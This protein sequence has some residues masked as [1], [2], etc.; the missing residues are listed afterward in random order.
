MEEK[1]RPRG[2]DFMQN[3]LGAW[4]FL[5]L[6]AAAE[7]DGKFCRPVGACLRLVVSRW[8]GV[9]RLQTRARGTESPESC[10]AQEGHCMQ[11]KG[12]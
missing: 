11:G 6:E 10:G 1:T 8:Q 7:Q 5:C 12:P 3:C 4:S 2:L 9:L